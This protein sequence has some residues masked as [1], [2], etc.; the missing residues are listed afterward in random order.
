MVESGNF[1]DVVQVFIGDCLVVVD[2]EV[3][4]VGIVS[5]DNCKNSICKMFVCLVYLK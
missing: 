3:G 5:G 2:F 4:E 1:G